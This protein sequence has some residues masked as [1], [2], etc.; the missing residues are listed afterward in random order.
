MSLPVRDDQRDGL[1]D[2]LRKNVGVARVRPRRQEMDAVRAKSPRPPRTGG[3]TYKVSLQFDNP[4]TA[5]PG[6]RSTSS[7]RSEG[8]AGKGRAVDDRR[9]SRRPG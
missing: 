6:S 1:A 2:V 7:K 9:V 3:S 5:Q 8:D 4:V